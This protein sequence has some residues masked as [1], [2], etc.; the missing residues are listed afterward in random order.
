MKQKFIYS[1]CW[2]LLLSMISTVTFGQLFFE[3]LVFDG[4]GQPL[5]NNPSG[6][7]TSPE[8]NHL[9]VI[10]FDAGA[11]NVYDRS[12]I[13]EL[14]YQTS[15]KTDIDGVSGMSGAQDILMSPEGNH[16]Y[17]AGSADNAVAVFRRNVET[18]ELNF[19]E[20]QANNLNGVVGLAGANSLSLS[21]DGN[22]LYV[23]GADDNAVVVFRRNVLSGELEFVQILQDENGDVIDLNYPVSVTV[24][25]DGKNVYA[26]SYG[27]YAMTVFTRDAI[28]GML[29]FQEVM[30]DGV[31]GVSGLG[32]AYSVRVSPDG[33]HV[34]C[35]G[36]DASS[37]ALFSRDTE[38]NL[39]FVEKYEDNVGGVDGL[40][41]VNSLTI[42]PDGNW[43][44]TTGGNDNALALFG[45]DPG[46]G[47]L[48]IKE[49]FE[50]GVNDVTGMNFPLGVEMSPD[51]NNLYVPGFGDSEFAVF[52]KDEHGNY[53]F[54]DSES[55][56][57]M[58][59]DGLG[60]ASHVAL[61]PD[62]KHVYV[63]GDTDQSLAVF[64]RNS[65]TGMMSFVSTMVD[66]EGG[67]KRFGRSQLCNGKPRWQTCLCQW[68][69]GQCPGCF[70]NATAAMACL[71]IKKQW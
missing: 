43:V 24:S 21:P 23:C 14:T 66:G 35:A 3:G 44:F 52:R 68:F 46:T 26:A 57:N 70:L 27:D 47:K 56:G 19:V 11:I 29:T 33:A 55:A 62:G 22:H 12:E 34:Y 20:K 42:S 32:G 53:A 49:K 6:I 31:N 17:V 18:G 13:G 64:D 15:I 60:G 63:T 10:S 58:G 37:I 45:R 5:L 48:A 41:G 61:S 36:L 40:W 28:S 67:R 9:Y 8:G 38:G 7:A 30:R 51:G 65:T 71:L 54:T 50:N 2:S 4:M 39:T 59:V 1:L 25:P 69:L 16:L